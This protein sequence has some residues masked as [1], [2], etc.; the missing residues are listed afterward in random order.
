MLDAVRERNLS[1]SSIQFS[2]LVLSCCTLSSAFQRKEIPSQWRTNP[3]NRPL[4][5]R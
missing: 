2:K 4:S 3:V 5:P 1:Y